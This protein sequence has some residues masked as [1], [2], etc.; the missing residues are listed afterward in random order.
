MKPEYEKNGYYLV[1]A[2]IDQNIVNSLTQELSISENEMNNYGVRD[3]M[4][5][6]PAIRK[7]ATSSPL[8]T[9][10]KEILGESVKPIRNG[11]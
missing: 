7:L 8:I 6:V 3:L 9:I 11:N 4:N 10:A 1:E 5:K 2:A